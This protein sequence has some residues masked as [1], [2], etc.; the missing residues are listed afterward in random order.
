MVSTV[1]EFIAIF[2]LSFSFMSL[3]EL[4]GAWV[5]GAF[6]RVDVFASVGLRVVSSVLCNGPFLILIGENAVF[7]E[8]SD[9]QSSL[10]DEKTNC[11][12]NEKF[13][14]GKEDVMSSR[15]DMGLLLLFLC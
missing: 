6:K 13:F 3:I 2:G 14:E 8:F 4:V 15:V 7:P 9:K 5:P 1:D 11:P 10:D 12:A